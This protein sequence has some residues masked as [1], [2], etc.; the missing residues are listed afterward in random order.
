MVGNGLSD[1]R[2]FCGIMDLPP[3]VNPSAFSK[4]QTTL[5]QAATEE[6]GDSMRKAVEKELVLSEAS[7]AEDTQER[8]QGEDEETDEE[9][10][11]GT[12]EGDESMESM[13]WINVLAV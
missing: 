12:E 10:D 5:L 1:L 11:D 3:P 9:T 7:K 4:L 13:E 6:A 8:R 2:V